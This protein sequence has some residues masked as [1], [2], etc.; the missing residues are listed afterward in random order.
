MKSI[1]SLF[2]VL[3]AVT[4][5]IAADAQAILSPVFT[6]GTEGYHTY[7]IPAI[8]VTTNGTV[9]AFCEGRRTTGSDSGDIDLLV[10]RSTD[11]GKTWSSQ[12][13]IWS[14]GEN[15]CGNPAP[16]L[17]QSTGIVWLLMTWNNGFDKEDKIHARTSRDTRRVW[18]THSADDGLTWAKPEEITSSVKKP[19]WDWYATG[20]VHGI[21]LTRG[22]RAGRLVIPANHTYHPDPA[23]PRSVSR[24]HVIYSDDHGRTWKIGGLEEEKTNESTVAELSDGSL[25]Q[26]MRSYH[27]QHRRAV[28]TSTDAGL[29]WS[30]V[31]LD[32]TLVEPVCQA[33]LLRCTWPE[34]GAKSRLLFS[35]P[36]SEKRERMTV[37]VS[38]DE[39]KTWPV[40]KE[41]FSGPAA[42]SDLVILPDKSAGCLFECGTKKAYETITLARFPLSWLEEGRDSR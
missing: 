36:A 20:P 22:A 21:Q 14:D 30:P 39:G 35:N 3:T 31:R 4:L 27:T 41:I 16:V 6:S 29:T 24:S 5:A 1:L 11:G 18:I 37:R 13:V 19:D 25:M 34:N 2:C 26:N 32:E 23:A 10:K 28:A 17:D 15:T 42:Y 9:L 12:Q 33:S 8:A 40:K 7:R 38:Y